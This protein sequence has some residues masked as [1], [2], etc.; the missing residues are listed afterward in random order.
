MR[1]FADEIL[2][3]MAAIGKR[4]REIQDENSDYD[5]NFQYLRNLGEQKKRKLDEGERKRELKVCD[6]DKE[7]PDGLTGGCFHKSVVAFKLQQAWSVQV[8]ITVCLS[9]PGKWQVQVT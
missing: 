4:K 8:L 7:Q 6:T 1:L 9:R 3:K 2:S 5:D